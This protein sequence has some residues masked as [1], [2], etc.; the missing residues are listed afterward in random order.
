MQDF[1]L[2]QMILKPY[3]QQY[4]LARQKRKYNNEHVVVL[5]LLIYHCPTVEFL[6]IFSINMR[7]I[8]EFLAEVVFTGCVLL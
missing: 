7:L 8:V 1:G 3:D 6:I 2:T 4:C 5:L